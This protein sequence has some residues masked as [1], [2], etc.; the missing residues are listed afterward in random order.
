MLL[1]IEPTPPNGDGWN[2]RT[3]EMPDGLLRTAVSQA[4][5]SVAIE[6]ADG[7]GRV[8]GGEA[9]GVLDV[10][11]GRAGSSVST[12]HVPPHHRWQ[13]DRLRFHFDSSWRDASPSVT[14]SLRHL[15]SLR[16]HPRALV[17]DCGSRTDLDLDGAPV[18]AIVVG[19]PTVA[20]HLDTTEA[21]RSVEWR[22]WHVLQNDDP[23][24]GPSL[25]VL[26]THSQAWW[27]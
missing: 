8:T 15:R 2:E 13:S 5:H 4:A 6:L 14:V 16:S 7:A 12:F 21:L 1:F 19:A 10:I 17:V 23:F 22:G 18:S 25:R 27:D 9:V 24:E 20:R 11:G 3:I 26:T